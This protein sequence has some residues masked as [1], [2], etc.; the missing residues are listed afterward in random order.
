MDHQVVIVGGGFAGLSAAKGL[1][2]APVQVTLV[3]RRNYHLFQPLLYQ[4]ATGSLSP[5]DIAAPLR[6]LLR[7]QAN[8]RVLLGEVVD[9][10]VARRQVVL[11][12]GRIDY[13]TLI[14]ATGSGHHY[15]GNDHWA[16]WAP[17]LKTIE[18]A[19]EIRNRVLTAFEMAERSADPAAIR[20]WLTFVI[21]GGGPT[22]VELAGAVAE[23]AHATLKHDFRSINPQDAQILLV[24]A[25]DRI[26]PTY[27]PHLSAAAAAQLARLG[28]SLRTATR[29]TE[30]G[31]DSA[32]LRS[33]G[34][35]ER[36]PA[37]TVLW[38]AGVQA[39][40]LGQVLARATGAALERGGRV[41]VE[42]DLSLPGHPEI[43][44]L[45]DLAA[46][47]HQTGTPLPGVAAV[48]AQQGQYV[49]GLVQR[50]L[51]GR[52]VQPFR[53]RD[54][55]SLATIG[56]AAAVA[57]FGRLH[58]TGRLAWLLWC[59]VHWLLLVGF[60]NR[61]LVLVQWLWSYVTQD[62]SAL[63]I[64]VRTPAPTSLG[65]PGMNGEF[66]VAHQDEGLAHE[67]ESR[68]PGWALELLTPAL[69]D[70]HQAAGLQAIVPTEDE[71]ASR[72]GQRGP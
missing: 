12:D 16:Q 57:D 59:V 51:Q 62:R 48:A 49:A 60:D 72:P 44:V 56:R 17:G 36:I 7:R 61:V 53:Y 50:R 70:G 18:D 5:A 45:G 43:F 47:P 23:I 39:S 29:V 21:V 35:E 71:D 14:I 30:V 37:R 64:T 24:Q 65:Q 20:A 1:K 28:V 2:G 67:G 41:V 25:T 34:G 31:P 46:Y 6:G 63:L 66:G 40:T 58:F 69:K 22:G 10:D 55:G 3:D 38:A 27:P 11:E 52:P 9:V 15:F 8:A 13:D 32:A 68:P 54:K 33:P 19:T 42:P 4:V 26:L